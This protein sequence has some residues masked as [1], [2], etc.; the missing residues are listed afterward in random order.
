M[1]KRAHWTE[2]DLQSALKA[3]ASGSSQHNASKRFN[4]PRRTLRNHLK[5]GSNK[6][7]LGRNPVLND[8]Q[9]KELASRILRFGVIGL[10]ITIPIVKSFVYD[11]CDKNGIKHPFNSRKRAAGRYWVEGFLIRHPEISKRKAQAM[12]PGRAA[13]LNKFIVKDYFQKLEQVM[14][15]NELFDKPQQIFNMDE[16]GCRLTLHH[17][18]KVLA[19]K[20]KK[21]V[22]MVA[23]EH[24][25][26]VTRVACANAAGYAIPP[27]I[28]FRGKRNKPEFQ[29]NFPPNT[30]VVMSEKGSITTELFIKWLHHFGQ[31]KPPGKVLLIFDGASSHINPNIVSV[32]DEHEIICMCLPSN[33]THEL[34]P[35]DKAVFK[36][37]EHF[38]DCEVL[39]YWRTHPDRAITKARFGLICTPA[40][41]QTLSVNNIISGFRSTGIYPFD[42]NVIPEEAFAPSTIFFQEDLQ[43][44]A[45]KE[46][47]D[48]SDHLTELTGETQ[49]SS[50]STEQTAPSSSLNPVPGQQLYRVTGEFE[51]EVNQLTP[52]KKDSCPTS[53]NLSFAP[54]PGPK[55]NEVTGEFEEEVYQ[56]T[57]NKK[58]ACPPSLTPIPGPQLNKVAREFE[59]EIHQVS[60]TQKDSCPTPMNLSFT[61]LMK[62]PKRPKKKTFKKKSLT[63]KAQ[64]IN[65]NL[66]YNQECH[67]KSSKKRE[68]QKKLSVKKVR[69]KKKKLPV[70]KARNS[71]ASWYC[72]VCNKDTAISMR[73]CCSCFIWY[74]EECIG[75]QSDDEDNFTCMDCQ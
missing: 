56:L 73:Q 7:K 9:E 50:L 36:S 20:G 2:E 49:I 5:T 28:I 1:R 53:M 12:N 16:K 17:Q 19:G 22:H 58:D 3:I 62:T 46:L 52:N 47:L 6:K 61:E 8:L 44:C 33:T 65:T 57:P 29:D 30:L 24:A 43:Q 63:Y 35:M 70:Q 18:Q 39:K 15:Q 4:I 42:P 10:P 74:H 48:S 34:Q 45:D 38:W 55:L 54:M 71:E 37:F 41:N 32:A 23:P 66:F 60:A 31:F 72:A 51:E 64:V 27:M 26:N 25:E 11:F 67:N 14:E 75:L 69:T 13:K 59:E 21:R 40:Y 68:N